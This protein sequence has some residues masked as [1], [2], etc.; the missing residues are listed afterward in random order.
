MHS[1][2]TTSTTSKTCL[3]QA[4]QGRQEFLHTQP[5]R[6]WPCCTKLTGQNRGSA[7]PGRNERRQRDR[8]R[9]NRERSTPPRTAE[10]L[11]IVS[12]IHCATAQACGK[13]FRSCS[14]CQ[15]KLALTR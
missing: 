3:A 2:P 9:P 1:S 8:R 15:R 4:Q 12:P 5:R 6:I 7:R 13:V 11:W 10:S 14:G